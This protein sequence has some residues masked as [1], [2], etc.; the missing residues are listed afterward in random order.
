MKNRRAY[1][2]MALAVLLGLMAVVLASHWLL[3]QN[4][5]A[6]GK[7]VVA[8]ADVNLGQRLTPEL[9]RLSDWPTDSLPE[10]ALTDVL[11][12][13][14]RVLKS[15]V[16]RGE[17]LSE[18]KLAPPGTLGGL[19][20]LI[21][22]GKRAITVRVNDVIGVAGFA[23][24]GNYVDILVNTQQ[25]TGSEAR[26]RS[27]AISKIVLERI[28]V[29]AVAQ[30]VGR[31]ETKPRVVNAVTL[32]VTPEQAE[33]LDLARS[34][35]SL[36]LALRNQVDPQPGVTGGATKLSLLGE[37]PETPA[38]PAASAP[39]AAAPAPPVVVK[40]R[41]AGAAPRHCSGL[42]DGTRLTRECF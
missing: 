36:S 7:I 9:L 28:L 16:L 39:T 8:S 23:L 24:P 13:N 17:P 25:E 32:E 10:G 22:E 30:E 20:A 42:I 31:D 1:A 4:S 5:A 34:V 14:G 41:V 15:S 6:S 3:R 12:L 19:S 33:K 29:L 37:Q 2:M 35:G 40:A 11:K 26:A 18:A 38:E 27:R 21:T